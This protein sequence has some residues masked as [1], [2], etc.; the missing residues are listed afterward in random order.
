MEAIDNALSMIISKIEEE[1]E[2][3]REHLESGGQ[4]SAVFNDGIIIISIDDDNDISINVIAGEPYRFN[5]NLNL[6]EK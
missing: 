1:D 6:I 2:N 4:V 3:L 5:Y